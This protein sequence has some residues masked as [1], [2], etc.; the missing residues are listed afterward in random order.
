MPPID[1]IPGLL[2]ERARTGDGAGLGRAIALRER[3]AGLDFEAR[4]NLA[5]NHAL[6]AALAAENGSDLGPADA[7]AQADKAI[8]LLKRVV[9][10][11]YRNAKMKTEPDLA[12]LR[13]RLDFQLLLLDLD[14][15]ADPFATAQ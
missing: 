2:L 3:L 8:E 6:L 15:P 10:D 4:Y 12:P 1:A 13:G 11:G 7:R 9:A 14:F 5:C